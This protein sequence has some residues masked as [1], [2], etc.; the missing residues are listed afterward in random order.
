MSYAGRESLHI[1]KEEVMD[2]NRDIRDNALNKR[3]S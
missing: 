1:K 2:L 3:K